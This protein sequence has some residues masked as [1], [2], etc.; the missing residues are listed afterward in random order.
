MMDVLQGVVILAVAMAVPEV[1]RI[2]RSAHR[3]SEA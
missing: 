1:R 2:L 3:R